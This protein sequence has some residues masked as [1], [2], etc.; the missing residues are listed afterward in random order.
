MTHLVLAE[1]QVTSERAVIIEERRRDLD[2]AVGKLD[3]MMT[4]S[5]FLNHPYRLPVLGW[6]HEMA[7]LSRQ[8]ALDFYGRWYAPD[9]AILVIAGDVTAAE[10]RPLAESIYGPI[11]S[12]TVPPRDRLMEPTAFAPRQLVLRDPTGH[13]ALWMR[14]YLAPPYRDAEDHSLFPGPGGHSVRCGAGRRRSAK[15]LCPGRAGGAPGGWGDQPPLPGS[16][17]RQGPRDG[18][19]CRL[20]RQ[21]SRLRPLHRDRGSAGRRRY[22]EAGTGG[23]CGA[24][25]ASGEGRDRGRAVGGQGPPP[26]LGHQGPGR[27][28]GAGAIRRHLARDRPFPGRGP[29]LGGQDR[30]RHRRRCHAGRPPGPQAQYLGHRRAARRAA[31]HET[32]AHSALAGGAARAGCPGSWGRFWPVSCRC[33]PRPPWRPTKSS[34]W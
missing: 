6:A 33:W 31:C 1:G 25:P 34:G 26:G 3:E 9:N 18:R 28:H 21:L 29:I 17:R 19:R 13:Q 30:R 20:R 5:L 15:W 22:G 23:R 12:R 7:K 14:R 10:V 16:R 24:R 11:P 32:R 27:A 2:S 8:D 4:A